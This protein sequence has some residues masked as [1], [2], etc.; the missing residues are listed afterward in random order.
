MSRST[1]GW[2][3]VA[4]QAALLATLILLP[5]GDAW[6][7]P[8]VL[9]GVAGAL[10]FGGLALVAVAALGLGAALTPTPVPTS[11][12]Q[13]TTGGLFRFMRHP[14]YTGVLLTVAGIT[15]RSANWAHL[16]V[17]AATFV[18]FNQKATWEEQQLRDR[19]PG[20]AE[21]AKRTPRFLPNPFRPSI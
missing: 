13:L 3:W 1:T 7:K 18:F 11:R 20:Y 16:A 17:A 5:G 15:L 8:S 19:Y 21:Y 6:A 4:G 14:I 2:L 12:G 9:L 10:F